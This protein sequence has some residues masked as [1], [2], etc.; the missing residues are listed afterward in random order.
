MSAERVERIRARVAE[1]LDAGEV[2]VIDE[3]HKHIGHAG[4][5]TGLGH[6]ALRLRSPRFVGA[7]TLARHR[8]VYDA[9]GE[10]MTTDIHAISIRALAPDE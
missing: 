8:M 5:A 9:L 10:M 7:S 1:A 2:E 6:F 4:A 3:G